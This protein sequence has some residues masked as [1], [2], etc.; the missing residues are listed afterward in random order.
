MDFVKDLTEKKTPW[1]SLPDYDKKNFSPYMTNLWLSMCPDLIDIVNDFQPVT[2]GEKHRVKPE[3]VYKLYLDMLPKMRFSLKFVK[4]T[5]KDKYN[6]DLL[7]L[8]ANHFYINTVIAEEYVDIIPKDRLAEIIRLYGK[9]DR[10]V[11]AL[12]K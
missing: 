12:L 10:E 1:A 4:K 2:M 9:T 7:K 11:K 5:K 8:I 6:K 3:H